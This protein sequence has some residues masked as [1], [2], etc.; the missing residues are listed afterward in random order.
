MNRYAYTHSYRKP[1]EPYLIGQQFKITIKG[2]RFGHKKILEDLKRVKADS[3]IA[4]WKRY[5]DIVTIKSIEA[6]EKGIKWFNIDEDIRIISEPV[7]K[8]FYEPI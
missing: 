7:L 8:S 1:H 2:I 3:S 4:V 6:V 5:P